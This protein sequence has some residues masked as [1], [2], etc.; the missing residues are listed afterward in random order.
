MKTVLK[1]GLVIWMVFASIGF[2]QDNSSYYSQYWINGLA[3]NPAYTGSRETLSL[4]AQYQKKWTGIEG[5]PTSQIFS[6]HAPMKKDRIALG[7][8]VVNQSY[9]IMKS[10]NASLNYAFRFRAGKGKMSLGLKAGI[11][12][13]NEDLTALQN[14][15][16]DPTDPA[17]MPTA[18]QAVRPGI[19]FGLYY[20]T[21][22]LY[23]G[24][25]IPEMINYST[26]GT[27]SSYSSQLSF[28][29]TD[30]S[31]LF[32]AGIIIGNNRSFKWRPSFMVNYRMDYNALRYDL[33]SSFILF[34]NR[35]WIGAGFRSGGSNPNPVLLGNAQIYVT[36]QLTIGYSYDYALGNLSSVIN[37]VHEIILRYEFGYKINAVNPRFF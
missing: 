25:S 36:P 13:E 22:K 34:D 16:A 32:S 21:E 3:I 2:S 12:M 1:T 23:L 11:S 35:I 28:L 30:Y 29:P 27:D 18:N 31:Y 26:V 14:G 9:G 17:F 6:A 4:L 7:L 8:L 10:T 15:L 20:Y 5:A 33:N 24:F 19:G 37:G